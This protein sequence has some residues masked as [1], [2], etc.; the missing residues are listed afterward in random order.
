[1]QEQTIPDIDQAL[2]TW[3][4]INRQA[5]LDDDLAG[6]L[7]AREEMDRLLELR[8]RCPLPRQREG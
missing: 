8:I 6:E 1:M 3:C 7:E 2:T 5:V 4:D